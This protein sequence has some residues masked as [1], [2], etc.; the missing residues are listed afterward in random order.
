MRARYLYA[1]V[2][3]SE[4]QAYEYLQ[5]EG[6]ISLTLS[7]PDFEASTCG[8][9]MCMDLKRFRWSC[10]KRGCRKEVPMRGENN[11]FYFEESSGRFH[12]RLLIN[13]ILEI[14]WFFLYRRQTIK[15]IAYATNHSEHTIIDRFNLMREVCTQSLV[16][17]PK[18]Y[19]TQD[20]P[21]Q[22]DESFFEKKEV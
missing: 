8:Y 7:C 1:N 18:M 13:A 16:S 20:Q 3:S 15:E 17:Q 19:G 11:F 14:I 5:E 12:A 6:L 4:E 22:I 10:Y 2:V 21:V 9:L